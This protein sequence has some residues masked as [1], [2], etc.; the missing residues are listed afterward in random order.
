MGRRRRVQAPLSF[1]LVERRAARLLI[2]MRDPRSPAKWPPAKLYKIAPRPVMYRESS[3]AEGVRTTTST[4][5]N[6]FRR[7]EHERD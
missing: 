4:K 5:G 7:M 2:R 3:L 6:G 1:F